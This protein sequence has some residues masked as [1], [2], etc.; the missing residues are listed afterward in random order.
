MRL[1]YGIMDYIDLLRNRMHPMLYP[2]ND[3]LFQDDISLVRPARM[4]QP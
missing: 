1:F 4:A 3:V 2:N